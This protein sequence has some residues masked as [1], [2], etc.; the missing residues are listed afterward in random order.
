MVTPPPEDLADEQALAE[1]QAAWWA[2]PEAQAA[3]TRPTFT[4]YPFR[5]G[6]ASGAPLPTG[7]VL[8]T[9]LAPEPLNGGGMARELVAVR[10][11][12]ADDEGFARIVRRGRVTARPARAHSVHVEVGG[13]E[14]G[15]WYFYRFIAGG[16]VSPTGRTRTAP[17]A[18]ERPPALRFAF[19]SCQHFEHGFYAAHRH[20]AGEGLDLMVF[21][22]DY[23]YEGP[24]SPGNVRRHRGGEI[25]TL[26]EYRNRHA[27]YKTDRDLQRLHAAVPWLVTWD[28]HE[29]DNDYAGLRSESLDPAFRRRRAAAYQAYFEHMPLRE[30]ARP[31]GARMILRSRHDFGT[32]ARFHML[33]GR[34]RRTPQACQLPGQGGANLISP[35][36]RELDDPGRTMLGAAQEQWLVNGLRDAPRRWHFI[37]QQTLMARAAIRVGT[38]LRLSNDGWDGYPAARDRVLRAI[39]EN[40]LG[41]CVVLTGDAHVT[42]VADLKRDFG[43]PRA[44]TVATELCGTSIT[45]RGR[46]QSATDAIVRENPHIR[47][48][49]S[50]RRGYAV[51]DVTPGRCTATLRVLDDPEDRNSGVSTSATFQ[52]EAGRPGVRTAGG[53]AARSLTED[54]SG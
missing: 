11:E 37:A 16:E 7:V 29:V 47:Y 30:L 19:G 13:L 17:P 41:S 43:D 18:G 10:W 28:D 34:Q 25:R 21:L 1:A 39:A 23:I 24:G 31:N 27:Q 14:P 15:R 48:G 50:A 3:Q 46:A 32:L 40:E 8:W 51:L 22:G 52:I 49:D 54:M 20:L 4:G 36:C 33:D 42:F 35:N 12:V 45:S 5:L 9:R 44:A 26:A 6:V 38:R 53:S 2:P